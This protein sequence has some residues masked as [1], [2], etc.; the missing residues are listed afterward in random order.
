MIIDGMYEHKNMQINDTGINS[1]APF[2]K[3]NSKIKILIRYIL[4]K[5]NN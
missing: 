3:P 5:T 1:K 2:L 4:L